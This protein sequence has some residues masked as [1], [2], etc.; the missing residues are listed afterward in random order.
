MGLPPELTQALQQ[1]PPEVLKGL[2]EQAGQQ[3]AALP[4]SAEGMN[5]AAP[6]GAL[7]PMPGMMG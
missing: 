7:P 4:P 3:Q 6:E 5:G 2:M 1:L